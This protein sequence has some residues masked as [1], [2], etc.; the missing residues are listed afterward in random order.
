MLAGSHVYHGPLFPPYVH[1]PV[2]VHMTPVHV[3][4]EWRMDTLVCGGL[5]TGRPMS[6]WG[7]PPALAVSPT[8]LG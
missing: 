4:R 8:A 5:E 6:L 7:K 3:L 1:K 2:G